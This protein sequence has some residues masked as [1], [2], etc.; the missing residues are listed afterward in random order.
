LVIDQSFSI[1]KYGR[2]YP[3]KFISL[4]SNFRHINW[5]HQERIKTKW[6]LGPGLGRWAL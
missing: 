2:D 4:K 3:L 6:A 5:N 1:N